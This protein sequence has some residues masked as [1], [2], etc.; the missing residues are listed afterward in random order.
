ML[1]PSDD[2]NPFPRYDGAVSSYMAEDTT[3]L[4][5]QLAGLQELSL[6]AAHGKD[7][8][9]Y[10]FVSLAR[11]RFDAFRRLGRTHRL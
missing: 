7:E 1:H 10:R 9:D 11:S 3:M 4:D 5:L 8:H 2:T 6:S